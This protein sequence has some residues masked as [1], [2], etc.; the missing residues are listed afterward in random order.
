MKRTQAK[1]N[2]RKL[3][4][5][6]R[7]PRLFQ[8]NRYFAAVAVL[9]KLETQPEL[10]SKT[11]MNEKIKKN[12]KINHGKNN[13]N[14]EQVLCQ[15]ENNLCLAEYRISFYNTDMRYCHTKFCQATESPKLSYGNPQP[16]FEAT[17]CG[18]TQEALSMWYLPP[19]HSI[20]LQTPL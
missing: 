5:F 8:V 15:N 18:C 3:I 20:R 19:M 1:K 7:Y 9:L 4:C 12:I 6:M 17:S 2:S 16:I 10:A 11:L 14:S 13:P